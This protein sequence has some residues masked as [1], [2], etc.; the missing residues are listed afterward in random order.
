VRLSGGVGSQHRIKA[1]VRIPALL[2]VALFANLSLPTQA[3]LPSHSAVDWTAP[4]SGDA[5]TDLS[6]AINGVF[7]SRGLPEI[8]GERVAYN[9]EEARL[10]SLFRNGHRTGRLGGAAETTGRWWAVR[11]AIGTGARVRPDDPD[12]AIVRGFHAD[13]YYG[14]AGAA[15]AYAAF[16]TEPF[17]GAADFSAFSRGRIV[18]APAEI[19]PAIAHMNVVPPIARGDHKW[20]RRPLPASVFTSRQQA[21]LATAIYFE[22]RGEAVKGQAAVAQV[23][24]NRVRNPAYPDTICGVVY[25]NAAQRNR[26]QFSFACDGIKDRVRQPGAYRQAEKIAAAVTSSKMFIPE[27]GSSTHY[28]ANYV[29]PRWA[30]RMVKMASIGD[31]HFFRTKKGGWK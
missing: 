25:Q 21:C 30:G 11:R 23:I 19:V 1:A 14:R 15:L 2:A 17:G 5:T 8:I 16:D 18:V 29:R 12:L 22:A 9:A 26:C 24:L 10:V 20:M 13:T 27:V 6:T 3:A 4:R 28:F 7:A 31:H